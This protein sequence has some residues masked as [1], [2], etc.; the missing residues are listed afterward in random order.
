MF[1]I[2]VSPASVGGNADHVGEDGPPDVNGGKAS[3][4]GESGGGGDACRTR[5]GIGHEQD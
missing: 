2:D 4:D 1:L 3:Q 5:S